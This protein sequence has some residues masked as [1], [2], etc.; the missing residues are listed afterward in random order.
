MFSQEKD[1]LRKQELKKQIE[2]IIFSSS[3]PVKVHQID[4]ILASRNFSKKS[5]RNCIEELVQDHQ[6]RDGGFKL[7]YLPNLGFQFQTTPDMSELIFRLFADKPRG[8]SK[9]TLETLAV[10]VYKQPVTR[11]EVDYVRGVDSGGTIR[12]LM[13]K[14]LIRCLGRKEDLGRPMIFGTTDKFLRVFQI[15]H[16][17][18]LPSLTSFQTPDKIIKNAD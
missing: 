6:K 17:N 14:K 15:S 5:L 12:G 1:H 18:D 2:A 8:F 11:A 10:V 7:V 9:A 13:E 3:E 4:K 16:L